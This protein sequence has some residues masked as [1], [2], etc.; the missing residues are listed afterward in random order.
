M[1]TTH[2]EDQRDRSCDSVTGAARDDA[3]SSGRQGLREASKRLRGQ[4]ATGRSRR[5]H[6]LERASVSK[7]GGDFEEKLAE[8]DVALDLHDPRTVHWTRNSEDPGRT[9]ALIGTSPTVPGEHRRNRGE[10][11]NVAD[12]GRLPPE[13]PFGRKRK[14]RPRRRSLALDRRQERALLPADE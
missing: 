14:L 10:G 3:P 5:Q 6:S 12:H 8:R 11:L 9:P 4:H 13:P 2:A 1:W 7:S